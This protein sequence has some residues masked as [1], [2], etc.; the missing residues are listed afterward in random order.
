LEGFERLF[1]T[2]TGPVP[3]VSMY[4]ENGINVDCSPRDRTRWK[5]IE[6]YDTELAY[7]RTLTRFV[8][9][10][11]RSLYRGER[12]C[13]LPLTDL[14]DKAA[15]NL[16]QALEGYQPDIHVPEQAI[17]SEISSDDVA[18][19]EKARIPKPPVKPV[20]I[21]VIE[22]LQEYFFLSVTTGIKNVEDEKFKCPVQVYLAC[23]GYNEDDTFKVP[24][25]ITS[26]LANWQYLLRCTALFEATMLGNSGKTNSVFA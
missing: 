25:E 18:D 14:L 10:G 19:S 11:L 9:A 21:S 12:E 6:Q 22:T 5:W 13:R 1:S 8:A 26:Q 7:A 2:S 23:Y 15:R 4:Q 16:L 24:S 17:V 3:H 20:P